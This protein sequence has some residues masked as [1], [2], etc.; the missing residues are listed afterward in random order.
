MN[1]FSTDNLLANGLTATTISATTYQGIG[2]K[3]NTVGGASFTGTPKTYDVVFTTAYPNTN[4]SI[5]ITGGID[6]TFTFESKTTTG[7]RI[8]SNANTSFTEN[9]DW[10]TKTHGES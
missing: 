9:V 5:S 10:I 7:F 2:L 4:Y 6:R 8:N 1:A 3:S